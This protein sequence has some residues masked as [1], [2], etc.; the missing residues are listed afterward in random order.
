[1]QTTAL[2]RK[3]AVG[4][5]RTAYEL[6]LYLSEVKQVYAERHEQLWIEFV[7]EAVERTGYSK[8]K[9]TPGLEKESLPI[10]FET[11]TKRRFSPEG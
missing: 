9:E 7:T 11:S 1:M 8:L 4:I 6:D 10:K 3:H 5:N 2:E